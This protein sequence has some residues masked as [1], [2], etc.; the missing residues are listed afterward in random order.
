M[1]SLQGKDLLQP[2]M[3]R[4]TNEIYDGGVRV[5]WRAHRSYDEEMVNFRRE[6][7]LIVQQN[8]NLTG[9]D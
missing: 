7:C 4:W 6:I 8:L 3:S 1:A 5:Q 9:V 2:W